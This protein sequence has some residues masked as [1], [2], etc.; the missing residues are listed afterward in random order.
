MT[1]KAFIIILLKDYIHMRLDL[2]RRRG[3]KM[4]VVCYSVI[5]KYDIPSPC[6]EN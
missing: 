4:I 1:E 5:K 3:Q 2:A 6:T